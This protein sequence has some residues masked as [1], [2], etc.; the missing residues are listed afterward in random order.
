M[1]TLLE[2]SELRDRVV[3]EAEDRVLQDAALIHQG[4]YAPLRGFVSREDYE[5]ILFQL[6]TSAGDPWTIPI[7]LPIP[8]QAVPRIRS[9]REVVL[10]RHGEPV[11][12]VHVEEIFPRSL[13][14]EA[15]RVYGT[16]DAHHPGVGAIL[17]EAHHVAAGPTEMVR[18][19]LVPAEVPLG[20]TPREARDLFQRRG[21]RTIVGFQTRN[22]PHRGHEHVLRLGLE[23]ADGLFVHPV[24]GARAAGDLAPSLVLEAYRTL[25]REYFPAERVILSPL[26]LSMRYAGPREAV[27]HALVRRN[28]GCTHFIVGRDHAGVGGCYGNYDA[29]HIFDGF[30]QKELGIEILRFF[31]VFRC[32]RCD[33]YVTEKTCPHSPDVRCDISGTLVRKTLYEGGALDER[34]V[35]PEVAAVLY[36]GSGGRT[37]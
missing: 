36:D 29:H 11:A 27:H 6:R 20:L 16:T 4:A 5:S 21:F 37:E 15:D 23:F 34:L 10:A 30:T 17:S 2:A 1:T 24:V 28:F 22:A 35:R 14:V 18:P 26:L 32:A 31:A 9:D 33:G 13:P 7:T 3:I 19:E 8:E 12:L 25:L